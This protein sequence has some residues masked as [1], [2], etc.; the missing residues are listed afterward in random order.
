MSSQAA[1]GRV[2][3]GYLRDGSPAGIVAALLHCPHSTLIQRKTLAFH[4]RRSGHAESYDRD[5]GEVSPERTSGRWFTRRR[6]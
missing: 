3:D 2:R 5:Q 6:T 4:T 1:R